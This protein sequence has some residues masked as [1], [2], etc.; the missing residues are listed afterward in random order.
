MIVKVDWKND[1]SDMALEAEG[2]SGHKV[3]MDSA[4]G[5]GGKDSGPRPMELLLMGLG[6]CTAMDV[7]SILR[8]KRQEVHSLEIEV[9][10]TRNEDFP[11]EYTS[12][13]LRYKIRGKNIDPSSVE[14]AIE[15]SQEKYCGAAET[16]RSSCAVKHT[17]EIIE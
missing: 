12:V 10:G 1:I 9:D 3:L 15:L 2:P 17:Y 7:L 4:S 13:E 5:F 8:K 16:F 14:R 6:G 11:K